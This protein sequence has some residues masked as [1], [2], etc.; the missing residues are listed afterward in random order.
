[1]VLHRVGLVSKIGPYGCGWT[2]T[3]LGTHNI[4]LRWDLE[5]EKNLASH[6]GQEPV[7]HLML[8]G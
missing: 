8:D 6:V 4:L 1:M 7:G 3:N 5:A 2:K